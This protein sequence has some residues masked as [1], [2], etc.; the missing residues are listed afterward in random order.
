MKALT[1]VFFIPL[2]TSVFPVYTHYIQLLEMLSVKVFFLNEYL[3][4]QFVLLM[5]LKSTSIPSYCL[6]AVFNYAHARDLLQGC[7]IILLTHQIVQDIEFPSDN[8]KYIY[9]RKKGCDSV[10][11]L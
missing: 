8:K 1:S 10:C 7:N 6:P 3:L 2:Q 9:D 11:T 5:E 4:D